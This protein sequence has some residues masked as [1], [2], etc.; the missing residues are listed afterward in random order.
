MHLVVRDN[1]WAARTAAHEM[2]CTTATTMTST[3][4]MRPP[5][6]FDGPARAVAHEMWCTTATTIIRVF[7][8]CLGRRYPAKTATFVR[9]ISGKSPRVYNIV[10]S[11]CKCRIKALVPLWDTR[12]RLGDA[13]S[14]TF[15]PWLRTEPPVQLREVG[16]DRGQLLTECSDVSCVSMSNQG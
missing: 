3:V 5:T 14:M 13:G 7:L 6:C 8:V 15:L 2:W 1:T 9:C 12:C 4:P 16:P 10:Y 11:L